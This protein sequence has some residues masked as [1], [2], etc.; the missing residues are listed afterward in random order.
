MSFC[1]FF[2]V[3]SLRLMCVNWRHEAITANRSSDA[4]S[5]LSQMYVPFGNFVKIESHFVHVAKG[6]TLVGK[7]A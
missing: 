7:M 3:I 5:T 6:I 2:S 4:L 1:G